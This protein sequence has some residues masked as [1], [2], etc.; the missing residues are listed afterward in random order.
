M[1]ID[2]AWERET[3]MV[4]ARDIETVLAQERAI[5][6]GDARRKALA[7]KRALARRMRD[8]VY[9]DLGLVKVKGTDGKTY[10]E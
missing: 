10:Y 5:A 2:T 3:S 4:D 8:A 6:N 9:R 1:P 7:R